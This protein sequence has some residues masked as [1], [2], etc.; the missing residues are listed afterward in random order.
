MSQAQQG[1]LRF[2]LRSGFARQ[3]PQMQSKNARKVG[4]LQAFSTQQLRFFDR[5]HRRNT[6]SQ[7]PLAHKA[8]PPGE[9]LVL[10]PGGLFLHIKKK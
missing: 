8:K 3:K 2:G 7:Q 4:H 10:S 5:K 6:E 9:R 1:L